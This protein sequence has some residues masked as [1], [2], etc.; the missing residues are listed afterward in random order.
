MI[1][2]MTP[3]TRLDPIKIYSSLCIHNGAFHRFYV[4]PVPEDNVDCG[5]V[6]TT[7]T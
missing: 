6:S 2:T 3:L 7:H 4:N 5:S 1:R